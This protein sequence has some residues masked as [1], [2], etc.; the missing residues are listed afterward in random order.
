MPV[1]DLLVVGQDNLLS[2]Q[3]A[4]PTLGLGSWRPLANCTVASTGSG[5]QMTR[6]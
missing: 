2:A 3:D 5:L 6:S 1:I 4:N